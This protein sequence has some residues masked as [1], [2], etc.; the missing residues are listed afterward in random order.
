[1]A[2]MQSRFDL[3]SRTISNSAVSEFDVEPDPE[4]RFRKYAYTITNS[5]QAAIEAL[6]N[7]A[8]APMDE[9]EP[10][11]TVTVGLDPDIVDYFKKAGGDW[12]R[13]INNALR[14]S[15]NQF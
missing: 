10:G 9:S 2:G 14:A 7:E 15:I 5:E 8:E 4:K 11:R 12:R 3:Y 13:R 1:M 6:V